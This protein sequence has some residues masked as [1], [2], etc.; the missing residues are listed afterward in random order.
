MQPTTEPVI[1]SLTIE[2][3]RSQDDLMGAFRLVY[4]SYLRAGLIQPSQD[5][6]RVTAYHLLPTTEVFIAKCG[7]E[8]VSTL[9]LMIDGKL[10]IPMEQM[11]PEEVNSFRARGLK[12]AEV[13]CLADRR[14]RPSRYLETFFQMTRLMAQAAR[15]RGVDM[16]IAA[17]HPR[18]A[19]F[20][21]QWLGFEQIGSPTSCPYVSDRPAVALC[22]N[23]AHCEDNPSHDRYF[24]T[25]ISLSELTP[26]T[27][28]ATWRETL[29]TY[30]D[31]VSM[32]ANVLSP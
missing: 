13:G 7:E 28:D 4:D 17:M 26:C 25:P 20:Y 9:S 23:I 6:I 29:Q 19:R 22:L 30:D 31:K 3:A 2:I 5:Q 24:G 14:Q 27:W 11:Y 8:V 15:Y 32:L 18:H 21:R 10:G 12:V 16:L 1:E